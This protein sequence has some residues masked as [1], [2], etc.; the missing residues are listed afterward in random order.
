MNCKK[1]GPIRV[2]T[3]AENPDGVVEGHGL[4]VERG[5][6][7]LLVGERGVVVARHLRAQ[8]HAHVAEVHVD[9]AQVG[10]AQRR[11]LQGVGRKAAC[12]SGDLSIPI[13]YYI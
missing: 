11:S 1:P 4:D 9:G 12:K 13:T 2:L 5:E 3:L 7:G 8:D 10:A 6:D